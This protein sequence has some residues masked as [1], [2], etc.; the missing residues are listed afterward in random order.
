M[1]FC[2][3]SALLLFSSQ[4]RENNEA[5]HKIPVSHNA[6]N[7]NSASISNRNNS[8]DENQTNKSTVPSLKISSANESKAASKTNGN[9]DKKEIKG[10]LKAECPGSR[11]ILSCDTS[12]MPFESRCL[13]LY[14][15]EEQYIG[16]YSK[17]GGERPDEVIS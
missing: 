12:G 8:F 1:R 2:Y 13:R 7:K 9:L 3:N 15:S 11:V 4:E 14:K 17:F 6:P 10:I 5:N 16:R